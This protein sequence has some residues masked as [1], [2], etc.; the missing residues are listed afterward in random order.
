M[1]RTK[2]ITLL[3]AL[4]LLLVLVPGAS[5]ASTRLVSTTGADAGDCTVTACA[6]IG[7]A[8]GQ[9]TAGDTVTVAAGT[10]SIASTVVLDKA[11]TIS[12][13]AVGGGG[14]KLE[15]V[16]GLLTVFEIKASDVNIQNLEITAAS[17]G[18][19]NNPPDNELNTSLIKIT[20]GTSM[21]GIAITGNAIYVPAQSGSMTTWNAR[22]ITAGSGT[23]TGL[24]ITGNTIRNTRNGVVIHYN[25]TA[26]ISSNT[27]YNTKGGIMNYTNS[28]VDADNRT[29]SNNTWT[30]AHSEWDI[31][32]NSGAGRTDQD[33]HKDVLLLSGANNGAYVLSLMTATATT[34]TITGNRSH[35]WVN[36]TTG[37]TTVKGAN[38][39]MNLPYQTIQLGVDAA[40]PGGTVYVAAG[41]Y[42]QDLVIDKAV[43]LLGTNAAIN[44]NT[45]MRVTEAVLYPKTSAP[46]PAVCENMVYLKVS[47]VT[48]KGFTFDG[49]NPALTTGVTI[50]GANVDA[51]EILAGYEGMGNIVVENNI[52][53][54]ATYAGVDFYNYT[55]PAATSGSY[56]RYNRFED[57]GETTYNWGIGILLYNNFY[58]EV[59][60]NVLTGVRTGVQ[61][62]NYSQANPGAPAKISDNK[63]GVWR[64]GIFHNLAYSNASPFTISGNTIVAETY[65]GAN[66]WNGLLLSSI[67]SPVNATITDNTIT[68]PGAVSFPS[69]GYTAGY[70]VWNVTTSAPITIKGG[71]VTGGDYGVFVNNYEGY[72]SDANNTAVK[73]DGVAILGSNIA[74]VYVKDSPANTNGATVYANIQ[75][76]SID[77]NATGILVEGADATAKANNSSIAGNTTIGVNNT[78]TTVMDATNNWWGAASGPGPVGP[79]SGDSVSTLRQLQPLADHWPDAGYLRCAGWRGRHAQHRPGRHESVRLPV[80][81]QL[82]CDQ[83]QCNGRLHQ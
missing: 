83:G 58:A 59:T 64:L 41:T 11:L 17:A 69:P 34:T 14:A 50:N 21:T 29:M 71:T 48:V 12:V 74:G 4:A 73:I 15:A 82:R 65:P 30:T 49:D 26:T 42:V 18:T 46:D 8:V 55:N 33:Y 10:Y 43:T 45:G 37:T 38:G 67:G 20:T 27:I 28:Q 77:T 31:V 52:L 53:K 70:N 62:G 35:V 68:I 60:N 61:T 39:N 23:V 32:W 2:L 47:N 36:S 80:Q 13:P 25:N 22:A 56:I 6:T 66:K 24:S 1:N 51:C 9:A 79:G 72:S 54:H 5:A 78:T 40:V 76:C 7:Y 3:A 44:P 63:I 81:D 75:S 16:T 57:I 19:F